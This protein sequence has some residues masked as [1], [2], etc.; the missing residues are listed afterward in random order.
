MVVDVTDEV[1]EAPPP[2]DADER[3]ADEVV[4]AE[5]VRPMHSNAAAPNRPIV[6][7]NRQLHRSLGERFGAS[8]PT[9]G[10]GRAT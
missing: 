9:G 7:S 3:T 6:C 8:H 4:Q 5:T 2:G 1:V 10:P